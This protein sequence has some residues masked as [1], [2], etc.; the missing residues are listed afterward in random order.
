MAAE[1]PQF[2]FHFIQMMRIGVISKCLPFN[3]PVKAEK[4]NDFWYGSCTALSSDRG[5]FFKTSLS[6]CLCNSRLPRQAW[7]PLRKLS[8][9]VSYV[10]IEIKHLLMQKSRNIP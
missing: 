1:R 9:S 5:I 2:R 3:A 10:L 8:V 4:L 6:G 7:F